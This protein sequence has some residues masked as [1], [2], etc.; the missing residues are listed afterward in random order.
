[1]WYNVDGDDIMEYRISGKKFKITED[2]KNYVETKL[3]K[4]DKYFETPEKL[5]E[6]IISTSLV[7]DGDGLYHI[8]DE[9]IY[10]SIYLYINTL[11]IFEIFHCN[12]FF[13]QKH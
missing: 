4:L 2:I 12:F 8:N 10:S 3:G 9:Y 13:F 7:Q 5:T 6:K 1:M 11:C